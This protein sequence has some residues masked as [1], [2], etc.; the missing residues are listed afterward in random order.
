MSRE[1]FAVVALEERR[2]GLLGYQD[3]NTWFDY[4][5]RAP[6]HPV[7]GQAF[8]LAP[9][10]RRS[11]SGSVPEWFANL[12]PEEGSGLRRLVAAD[13][14]RSR[15]HDFHLLTYLGGDLPGAVRVFP[16]SDIPDAPE[17]PESSGECA[18][19]H[20]LR[21]SLAG[22]QPKFSMYG[23]GKGLT[24]PASGAGG[25]WIVKLPD[26]RF[27]QVPRNEYAM[28]TWLA[29]S[30][31][32][33]PDAM[34][35]RGAELAGL[36]SGLIGPDEDALAIRRFDRTPHGR[37]HQED[38]AQVR[39]VAVVSKYERATYNGLGRVVRALCPD[40]V[41]EYVRRLAAFVVTGN[42]DAHLKNWSLRYPDNRTARLAPAYDVVCVTAYPTYGD[43]RLAFRLGGTDAPW[44]VTMDNFRHLARDVGLPAEEVTEI[45]RGTVAAMR[46]SWPKLKREVPMPD[47]VSAHVEE[48][49][50]ALPLC[51]AA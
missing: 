41:D 19:D 40:D 26:R 36:P 45:V 27:D 28:L 16:L 2:V 14:G 51:R 21:F 35:V 10:R 15:I 32:D 48:R 23:A 13:L 38:F 5:D 44:L 47:F 50:A 9:E 12:L 43:E 8:E 11:A 25:D 37:V 33:V 18:D 22:V 39:E 49:L 1:A 46:S 30:G 20:L 34:L 31:V 24:L 17:P 29:S 7:L 6:D 42:A 3:G 4:E